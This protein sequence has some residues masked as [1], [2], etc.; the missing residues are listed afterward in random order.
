MRVIK[1]IL[2]GLLILMVLLFAVYFL[3]PTPS[4][5]NL[6]YEMP[7]AFASVYEAE[8]FV[9]QQESDLQS[10][11]RTDNEARIIWANDSLK[12]KTNYSIV[13]LHGFGASQGEGYPVHQ[14][15]SKTFNAN[16]FLA[17]LPGHGRSDS[18]AMEGLRAGDL[19]EGTLEALRVAA[20]IGDSVI[21]IGTS[22]GG[23]L[24]LWA[25]PKIET[26]A[27]VVLYSPI[28]R[29]YS[30]STSKQLIRPWGK[31]IMAQLAGGKFINQNRGDGEVAQYWTS[32]Y[33]VDA[34][35]ALMQFV[36]AEMD[37][38]KLKDFN[39][40]L[41]LG[42]YY[43]NEQ[44]QDMVVS[45]LAMKEMLTWISTSDQ[46]LTEKAFP[47]SGNHVI[48]S[49]YRSEDYKGVFLETTRFLA[50]LGIAVQD[51]TYLKN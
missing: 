16:L 23:A 39:L 28:I 38:E 6:N 2:R 30:E 51:S 1:K 40:P 31:V 12:Q 49:E 24:A 47:E 50:N 29:P 46:K 5:T 48:A 20:A 36:Y 19:M 9:T 34:Y 43:K 45:V 35:E 10:V 8:S 3:G 26:V 4:P 17:R 22:T 14:W 42:Y 13:Y 15:L 33:H 41:F 25:A 7:P 37:E 11:I 32:K 18:T 27:S 21:V 44:E